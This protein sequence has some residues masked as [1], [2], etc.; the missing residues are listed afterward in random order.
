MSFFFVEWKLL[1]KKQKV[2]TDVDADENIYFS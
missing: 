1:E 2:K